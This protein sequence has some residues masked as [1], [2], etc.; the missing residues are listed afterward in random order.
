MDAAIV[1]GELI[2]R[3]GRDD[4]EFHF[5]RWV[6]ARL[7]EAGIHYDDPRRNSYPDL[8]LVDT[9][10]GIEVKGLATPGRDA[11]FDGNSQIAR[12][13]HNKRSIYYAFG[14][15]PAQPN[16]D[17]FPVVDLVVVP[18]SFLN[19]DDTYKHKNRSVRGLGSYGD[20]LLRD[21]KMYV[22]P[23]PLTLLDGV[24]GTR[25]LLLPD[26]IDPGGGFVKVGKITRI[27]ATKVM[28]GYT[29]DLTTRKLTSTYK[30]N[31]KAGQKH[32]FQ[33]WR[34][35]RPEGPGARVVLK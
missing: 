3:Q 27:E 26:G 35:V 29:F 5:Q 23:T 11:S 15:Y 33:A 8:T 34:V 22:M 1:R 9:P 18:G 21:R 13:T 20:I 30:K 19:A 24:E 17:A 14:R 32:H 28:V 16:G 6:Q 25:T 31:P 10:E 2:V 12:P 4:K 7:N